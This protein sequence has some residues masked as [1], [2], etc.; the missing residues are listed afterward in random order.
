MKEGVSLGYRVT[1]AKVARPKGFRVSGLRVSGAWGKVSLRWRDC[2]PGEMDTV[3][4][5][6]GMGDFVIGNW[7]GAAEFYG[8]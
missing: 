1:V 7:D 4:C 6:E 5:F 2:W 3:A 8:D